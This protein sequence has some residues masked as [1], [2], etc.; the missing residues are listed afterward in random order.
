MKID[1]LVSVSCLLPRV[2]GLVGACVFFSS[3]VSAVTI[4]V[5]SND[6][7][8][9]SSAVG[10]AF[11]TEDFN[12]SILNPGLTVTTSSGFIDA[13]GFWNDH[14]VN[15][16]SSTT[17]NF[18]T[19]IMGFGGNWDLSPGGAGQGILFFSVH[20][21]SGSFVTVPTEI[22]DTFTGQFFG[23][24]IDQPFDQVAYYGGTQMG[25]AETYHLDN[26]V[27]APLAIGN[28]NGVPDAGS[29]IMMLGGAVSA[30][31]SLRR[32]LS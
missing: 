28:G 31:A 30:L 10:G 13:G 26:L 11:L 14:V 21:T 4:T 5:Y 16:G 12:D 24:T 3:N 7:P 6:Q 22:P 17:W 9:W 27:Y 20:L 25:I 32:R 15:G 23:F 29:T 8:G 2:M 19:P 1:M 18:A